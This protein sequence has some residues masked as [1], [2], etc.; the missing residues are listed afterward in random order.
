ME[1]G[2]IVESQDPERSELDTMCL[3]FDVCENSTCG[4]GETCIACGP[5]FKVG[6]FGF[7]KLDIK[8]ASEDCNI[9]FSDV[10]LDVRFPQC[11]HRVC[12][13][14]FRDLMFW[15]ETRHHLDRVPFGCPRCPNSC[16][17]P[18]RGKQCECKEY[19]MVKALWECS[20]PAQH[21]MWNDAENESIGTPTDDCYGKATCPFCRLQYDRSLHGSF[22]G[23][24]KRMCTNG[25]ASC[26]VCRKPGAKQC[27]ACKVATYC[28]RE[29]QK[30]H[31]NLGHK[32]DCAELSAEPL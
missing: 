12:C 25:S 11:S 29:C 6:G 27:T 9:C 8:H 24:T 7:G 15:D 4:Q 17:N 14:C 18:A 21:E 5:W 1:S 30:K 3:N 19:D 28:S 31:W 22:S 10:K 26:Y 23:Y 2:S 32:R 13:A 16:S 20:H